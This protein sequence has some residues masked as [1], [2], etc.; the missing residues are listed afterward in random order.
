MATYTVNDYLLD[1]VNIQDTINK[2]LWHVDR[3]E[4]D[5]LAA[6]IFADEII[7]DYTKMLGGEPT[8]TTGVDQVKVWKGMLDY[9]DATQHVATAI[10]V[11]LA[12]PTAGETIQPPT[13]VNCSCNVTVTLVRYA[14]HGDPI[15]QNGGYYTMK[16]VRCAPNSSGNPWRVSV[17]KAHPGFMTGN[18]DVAKNPK[19]NVG[20][21]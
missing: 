10:L 12:Q 1:R 15:T 16:V 5:L 6:Q 11:D 21:L 9:M 8:Y 2:L 17:F 4:W 19:T 18:A 7:V 13:E 3:Q 14:A 20:W